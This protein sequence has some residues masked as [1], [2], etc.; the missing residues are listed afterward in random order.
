MIK[1]YL[2][3]KETAEKW[4][5][6][7]RRIQ[8]LCTNGRIAG[9]AKNGREWAIPVDARKPEDKRITTGEY[10]NWRKKVKKDAE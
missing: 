6:T 2:S 8:V 7:P 5:V 9:A 3:I 4:G 1:G 10:R